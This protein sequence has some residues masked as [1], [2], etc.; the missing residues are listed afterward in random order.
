MSMNVKPQT[1]AQAQVSK[2][3][4][5]EQLSLEEIDAR[6]KRVSYLSGTDELKTYLEILF[7]IRFTQEKIKDC[8]W[9]RFFPPCSSF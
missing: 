7:R 4:E 6:L 1:Q 5:N 9:H 8:N 3:V 2:K